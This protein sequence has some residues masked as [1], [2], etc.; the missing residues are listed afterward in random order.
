MNAGAEK[1]TT[2]IEFLVAEAA[3]RFTDEVKQ[4]RSPSVEN[5]AQRYPEIS[6]IIRQVFPALAL[7]DGSSPTSSHSEGAPRPAAQGAPGIEHPA[8]GVLGDFRILREIGR[9]GMGVVYE[10]EQLSIGRRVALKVLPFAAMLDKQQLNRFKNE[11]RAAGTLDHPNIVA[12]HSVGVERGVHYYAMQLVDGQS[13]AQVIDA[14]IAERQATPVSRDAE[15]RR[16]GARDA[17]LA[18]TTAHR[19]SSPDLPA[20]SPSEGMGAPSTGDPK[21]PERRCYPSQSDGEGGEAGTRVVS[22]PPTTA[23]PGEGSGRIL[24]DTCR[25]EQAQVSTLP[26]SPLVSPSSSLPAYSTREYFRTIA[27]L[28]VQAAEALDH[29][30]QN[31]ILH[32]DVKPANLLVECSHLACSHL[33]PRDE[34]RLAERD[35]YKLERDGYKLWITDFGLAR[36]EQDAGMTMTGDLLG[37][38][39][40]M[41]PEQALAKRVVVDHRSDIYSLGV[42]LYELLTLE[43]AYAAQ[44]RQEL[45][46]QIAFEEPRKPRQVNARLPQDLETIVLKSI[47]KNPTDRYVTA[48]ELADDLRRFVDDHSI[49]ARR[50]N[51]R[52]RMVKWSRRNKR[53]VAAAA[54]MTVILLIASTIGSILIWKQKDETQLAL[55][56]V[57][58]QRTRAE[59]SAAEN[60]ALVDFFVDDLLGAVD[61]EKALGKKVTV[62]EVLAEAERKIE[63]DL[64]DQPLLEAS[65]RRAI[66]KIQLTLGNPALAEKQLVRAREIQQRLLGSDPE[67]LQTMSSLVDAL[68]DQ[69]RL[70]EARELSEQTLDLKRRV[71]GPE[72]P[73][74]LME[75]QSLAI[76]LLNQAQFDRAQ[77]ILENALEISR[78]VRGP[79]H[80]DTLNLQ[81]NLA[82][83]LYRLG[84]YDG[85][86][87]LLDEVVKSARRVGGEENTRVLNMKQNLANALNGFGQFDGARKLYE[88]VLAARRRI[89]G[90]IHPQTLESL[91][92]LIE[93][94][95]ERGDY[96]RALA[97]NQEVYDR[98]TRE[99]GPAHL[100]TLSITRQRANLL[101]SCGEWDQSQQLLEQVLETIRAAFGTEHPDALLSMG[102]LADLF[103]ARG[104]LEEAR[105]LLEE[106]REISRRVNGPESEQTFHAMRALAQVLHRQGKLDESQQLFEETIEL[107]RQTM[108]DE[109]V[110]TLWTTNDLAELLGAQGKYEQS[111]E[112]HRQVLEIERRILGPSHHFTLVTMHNL[113]EVFYNQG[114]FADALPLKQEVFDTLRRVLGPASP[115]TLT[116]MATLALTHFSLNHLDQARELSEELIELQRK[117][118]GP[119]NPALLG[120]MNKL[121]IILERQGDLRGANE[122][123]RSAA[124]I[125]RRAYG[126][127]HATTAFFMVELARCEMEQ[128]RHNQ[129]VTLFEK[130]VPLLHQTAGE[131]DGNLTLALGNYAFA[132]YEKHQPDDASRPSEKAIDAVG[133]VLSISDRE[134]PSYAPL[135]SKIRQGLAGRLAGMGRHGEAAEL[136]LTLTREHPDDHSAATRA[137]MLLLLINDRPNH[138]AVCRQ[139]L[140]RFAATEDPDAARRT[141]W[142]CLMCD[143]PV[144]DVDTLVSLADRAVNDANYASPQLA[145]RERGLAAYR[146]GQWDDALKWCAESRG[147]TDRHDY[148]AQNLVIEAMSLHQLGKTSD[149]KATFDQAVAASQRAFPQPDAVLNQRGMFWLDWA[150]FEL[151]RREAATLLGLEEP[152]A[153]LNDAK[154]LP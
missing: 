36:I 151:L 31:G 70:V 94:S 55:Q 132:L 18:P 133:D 35:G 50:P 58:Q 7:L 78:R 145:R 20:P 134:T 64:Q 154:Q 40:Y 114:Q 76:C 60:K 68:Y 71:L 63:T 136:Y 119:E 42:T 49:K 87:P 138:E 150:M 92:S 84:D 111:I 109:H 13:L 25:D 103:V 38:L 89:Y 10:A 41:S 139:M 101:R 106:R 72:H 99:L 102:D 44:D 28:G 8:S 100:T 91:G 118:I 66:G 62:E 113:A 15:V 37:T 143:P 115:D 153:A 96:D 148:T 57:Q 121:A 12:V 32:R 88:E 81:H 137:G 107:M 19:P 16:S 4:G 112:L 2:S 142:M 30:H 77:E 130:W 80:L 6:T 86:R 24:S 69:Q 144:G 46:R 85:A 33:A 5:Y 51:L 27:R 123:N 53:F 98:S 146:T 141:C 39:R 22:P 140:A 90:P 29:A 47:E 104:K 110:L 120:P 82:A 45:L 149:A 128:G 73:D 43:P 3:D 131:D 9:G 48:Q 83:V 1:T 116:A 21:S 74:T 61:P 11:A 17:V 34:R 129:A 97:L 152:P 147:L 54:L 23:R 122:V 108:G 124:Q 117:S 52:Q 59:N 75:M 93:M 105:R 56:E 67:T 14:L 127:K 79:E 65:I 26:G 125:A 126:D 95:A 135:R